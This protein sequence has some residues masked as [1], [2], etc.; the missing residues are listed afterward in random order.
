M[1]WVMGGV[2]LFCL[3]MVVLTIDEQE[4]QDWYGNPIGEDDAEG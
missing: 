1:A 2:V 4:P 3:L